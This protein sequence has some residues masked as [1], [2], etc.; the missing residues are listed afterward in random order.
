[1]PSP[2]RAQSHLSAPLQDLTIA[3]MQEDK[4]FV[5][6]QAATMVEVEHR[7]D[8]YYTY[9]KG[10]FNRL[11]MTPRGVAEESNGSGW[12]LSND[13]YD[14]KK[15]SVHK[16]L[17]WDDVDDTD[18]AI[19]QDADAAEWLANQGRMYLDSLWAT[20]CFAASVWTTEYTGVSANPSGAQFLQWNDSSSDPQKDVQ[21]IAGAVQDLI[22]RKPN[23]MVVG[24]AVHRK[25]L[26]NP[27]VRN[28]IKYVEPTLIGNVEAK[29]ADY[30]GIEKYI[31]A[32]GAYNSAQEGQT[33][34]FSKLLTTTGA[35]I[36]YVHP[37]GRGKKILTAAAIFAWK[38]RQGMGKNGV[39]AKKFDIPKKEVTRH[40]IDM[41]VAV[42]VVSADAGAFLATAVA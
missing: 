28:S 42:K 24:Q 6:M 27:E 7:T 20:A 34:S 11:E 39:V 10:A 26:T 13:S 4:A 3:T 29:L 18:E 36:G 15:Y 30:L 9:D 12:T 22:F 41:N 31:V 37:G 23:V 14:C 19:D 17:D 33:A 8:K 35:W 21:T 38:G 16:D 1:M 32:A 25:L 40:E 2:T 5:A